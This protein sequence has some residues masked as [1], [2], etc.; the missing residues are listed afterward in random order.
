VQQPVHVCITHDVYYRLNGQ[1]EESLVSLEMAVRGAD[2]WCAQ[3]TKWQHKVCLDSQLSTLP[4]LKE[5]QTQRLQW[6]YLLRI[7]LQFHCL[8]HRGLH[9]KCGSVLL[10]GSF[11]AIHAP[12]LS[13]RPTSTSTT[14]ASAAYI[15]KFISNFHAL[16]GA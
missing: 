10:S 8:N 2:T 15:R 7:V 13:L 12:V 6:S 14:I 11:A 5:T 16:D 1:D 9:S 4:R 3:C